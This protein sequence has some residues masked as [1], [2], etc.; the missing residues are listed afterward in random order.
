MP[1]PADD[2]P[3]RPQAP[4]K[5][6]QYSA[7]GTDSPKNVAAQIEQAMELYLEHLESGNPMDRQDFLGRFPD[8][9]EQLEGQLEALEFLHLAAPQLSDTANAAADPLEECT[10]LG[11]FRLRQPIGR[12]GMGIVY[13][14]EQLSLGRRVAVKVLPFAAMLDA[15]RLKRF[16]NEARSAATLE[17]P[18]IVPIHFVGKER[19]V[20]FYAMQLIDGRSLAEVI[21]A[22][23]A[24]RDGTN[25]SSLESQILSHPSQTSTSASRREFYSSV[26][27]LGAQAAEALQNAHE[28]GI[29]HRD[30]KPGNLLVDGA[31]KLWVTD[32]GLARL[33]SHES[34]TAGADVLGTLA[35]MSPEQLHDP[36]AIDLRTDIYSLGATLYELLTLERAFCRPGPADR[37]HTFVQTDVPP[38]RRFA[39]GIPLDLQTIVL[40][41][42]AQEPAERY[43][44]AAELAQDLRNFT[45]GASIRARPPSSLEKLSRWARRHPK[46]VMLSGLVCLLLCLIMGI[47]TALVW[48]ANSRTQAALQSTQ[49]HFDQIEQL[50]YWSDMERAYQAWESRRLDQV[51]QIL[52]QQIPEA[53]ETDLRRSEWFLLQRLSQPLRP[54]LIAQHD[55]PAFQVAVFPDASR[56]ASVGADQNLRIAHVRTGESVACL[57]AADSSVEALFSVAIS[58]DGNSVAT[59][60]DVVLRWDAANWG[61]PTELTRFDYNVQSLAFAPDGERVAA[62][63][64]YDRIRILDLNGELLYELEDGARHESLA[65]TSDGQQL[66]VPCRPYADQKNI[67][68]IRVMQADLSEVELELRVQDPNAFPSY[69]LANVSP[70]DSFFVVSPRYGMDS[71]RLLDAKS[72]EELLRMPAK[73]DEI[74]ATT[75]SPDGRILAIAYNDGS[76]DYWSLIRLPNGSFLKPELTNTL[77]AHRG[78]VYSIQFAGNDQLVSCGAD[79]R[80]LVWPVEVDTNPERLA[81]TSASGLE[82]LADG[83]LLAATNHGLKLF[84]ADGARRFQIHIEQAD[85]TLCAVSPDGGLVAGGSE[86][87]QVVVG[88]VTNPHDIQ[89]LELDQR[90]TDLSFAS[91]GNQLAAVTSGGQLSVWHLPELSR[92][93]E[94]QLSETGD[95]AKTCLSYSPDGAFLLASGDDVELVIVN[96]SSWRVERRVPQESAIGDLVFDPAGRTLAT[97]HA[98]GVIRIWDWPSLQPQHLLVGHDS[99]VTCLAFSPDGHTLA[100]SGADNTTRLWAPHSGRYFGTVHSHQTLPY[101]LA[102]SRDGKRLYV[103]REQRHADQSSGILIFDTEAQ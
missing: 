4:L 20:H 48:Q 94:I 21:H 66:V 73:R 36:L 89:V 49:E 25:A 12:G 14:A 97:A 61:Q 95:G 50:L 11:D 24:A 87:N 83:S 34:I 96:T 9:A 39:P 68:V 86:Q 29:V 60:S 35:Y 74:N 62:A 37:Q 52:S 75:I 58:P 100:S 3:A 27:R 67:G 88:S 15:K 76:I 64:R 7:P 70:D 84:D 46:L 72:G 13:E 85:N 91:S 22:M 53:G 26:A 42:M 69:T 41:A 59:G 44:T 71:A 92:I 57:S 93:G 31:G 17:H 40:K 103:G 28:Q 47:S 54:R 23:R 16:Q 90:P 51:R 63:S 33:E 101:G 2:L 77:Q 102:F 38:L 30:V 8:I 65:F 55:G 99:G 79:G 81:D 45:I 6:G 32:F 78:K 80:V 82:T 19:G 10:T 1:I 56:V 43:G 98:D 18:H 5:T